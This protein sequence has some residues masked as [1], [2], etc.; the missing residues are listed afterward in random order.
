MECVTRKLRHCHISCP[1]LPIERFQG[2]FSLC[3]NFGQ[4]H[5]METHTG[6]LLEGG[7]GGTVCLREESNCVQEVEKCAFNKESIFSL[8]EEIICFIFT[9]LN[10]RDLCRIKCCCRTFREIG[11]SRQ[12]LV[13]LRLGDYWPEK[14]SVSLLNCFETAA[15][16]GNVEACYKLALSYLYGESLPRDC[17]K[18]AAWLSFLSQNN[19]CPPLCW[20]LFRPPWPSIHSAKPQILDHFLTLAR[21]LIKV[22]RMDLLRTGLFYCIG[23]C[24]CFK[25]GE[26]KEALHWLNLAAEMGSVE[27]QSYLSHLLIGE[28]S[29]EN[30]TVWKKFAGEAARKGNMVA[31]INLSQRLLEDAS[32]VATNMDEKK[33]LLTQATYWAKLASSSKGGIGRRRRLSDTRPYSKETEINE[34]M[35]AILMDWL[36]V[37]SREWNYSPRTVFY[38]AHYVDEYLYRNNVDRDNFQLVGITSMLCASRINEEQMLTIHESVWMCEDMYSTAAVVRMFGEI[39]GVLSGKLIQ[40][41]AYDFL[42]LYFNTTECQNKTLQTVA[43]YACECTLMA[44]IY[45]QQP[46]SLVAAA[47][48]LLARLVLKFDTPWHADLESFT[49]Y[50][51]KS[52]AK[53]CISLYRLCSTKDHLSIWNNKVTGVTDKYSDSIRHITFPDFDCMLDRLKLS[54]RKS[55]CL[56]TEPKR[57]LFVSNIPYHFQELHISNLLNVS[58]GAATFAVPRS[59]KS[60]WRNRGYAFVEFTSTKAAEDALISFQN[61][62]S[63]LDLGVDTSRAPVVSWSK[64]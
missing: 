24:F 34:P 13:G 22:N 44:S 41:T 45:G 31:Q 15:S 58:T 19:T 14:Q 59:S 6:R 36:V 60:R 35:R 46:S 27:A 11:E 32:S 30:V 5:T 39:L 20:L 63:S 38:A 9:F 56:S 53:L 54:V 50:S 48:I 2:R 10:Y 43:T 42:L 55:K 18:A 61:C 62:L 8:P 23:M 40:P 29:E 25:R 7:A 33:R 64:Y 26:R 52:L 12:I 16:H 4:Q 21:Y 28:R 17:S 51:L 1:S 3:E 57:T 47:C 49:G 37:I